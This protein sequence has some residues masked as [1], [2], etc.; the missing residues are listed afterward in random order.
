MSYETPRRIVY[1]PD[2]IDPGI[3]FKFKHYVLP[4]TTALLFAGML[5]TLI[6]GI[7]LS[8]KY[9]TYFPLVLSLF[10]LLI[11]STYLIRILDTTL[12]GYG[13]LV[14]RYLILANNHK[15]VRNSRLSYLR[16]KKLL[17]KLRAVVDFGLVCVYFFLISLM[18]VLF[19]IGVYL[20][21]F[22]S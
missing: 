19:T 17:L 1:F 5:V 11:G 8:I 7:L 16:K 15:Y 18:F 20:I 21:H 4:L 9:V 13:Y 10:L 12:L 3:K 14:F 2:R 22:A 6:V